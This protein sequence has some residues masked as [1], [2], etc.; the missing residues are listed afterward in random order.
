MCGQPGAEVDFLPVAASLRLHQDGSEGDFQ[1][2]ATKACKRSFDGSLTA[3]QLLFAL[4]RN[5]LT[6]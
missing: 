6:G 3:D 4:L 1:H 5:A 2:V